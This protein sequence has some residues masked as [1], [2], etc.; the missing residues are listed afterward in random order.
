MARSSSDRVS[1]T[2]F[3]FFS[4]LSR[5]RKSKLLWRFSRDSAL[6][7]FSWIV[8]EGNQ[9]REKLNHHNHLSVYYAQHAIDA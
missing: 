6:I 1:S 8:R 4:S 7:F 9:F 3:F 2:K 5:G